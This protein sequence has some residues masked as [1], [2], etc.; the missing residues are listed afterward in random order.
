MAAGPA[1]L[2]AISRTRTP[3]AVQTQITWF[4]NILQV[5]ALTRGLGATLVRN[6]RPIAFA[7]KAL[8]PA[9][10]TYANIERELLV[11]PYGCEKY[12]VENPQQ[13]TSDQTH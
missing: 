4:G 8:T 9:E 11:V 10:T 2:H 12:M 3:D 6:G 5:D 13:N 7:S 1:L